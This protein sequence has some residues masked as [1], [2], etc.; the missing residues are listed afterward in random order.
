[1]ETR[2]Q[3]HRLGGLLGRQALGRDDGKRAILGEAGDRGEKTQQ[4]NGIRDAQ[5]WGTIIRKLSTFSPEG[6][7]N[8][9]GS[10]RPRRIAPLRTIVTGWELLKK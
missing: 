1:V 9:A 6:A 4:E 2:R 10:L 3:R 8:P 7:R 5:K